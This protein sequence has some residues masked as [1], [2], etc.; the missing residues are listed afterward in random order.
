MKTTLRFIH[1]IFCWAVLVF[2]GLDLIERQLFLPIVVVA[3]GLGGMSQIYWRTHL[4]G[5]KQHKKGDLISFAA[6]LLATIAYPLIV[7][8]HYFYT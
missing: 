2:L 3:I 5:S 1:P 6:G 8:W 4:S 7:C